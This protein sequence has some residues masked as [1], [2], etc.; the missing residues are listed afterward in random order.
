[1]RL[2]IITIMATLATIISGNTVAGSIMADTVC[3][4]G[5]GDTA[6]NDSNMTPVPEIQVLSSM[7]WKDDPES[8]KKVFDSV[9]GT[10]WRYF[11]NRQLHPILIQYSDKGPQTFYKRSS[12]GRYEIILDIGDRRHSQY[13]YQ[14]S[15]ELCHIL[16]GIDP[17]KEAADL[18]NQWFEEAFC[19][20]ASLFTLKRLAAVWRVFPPEPS[21]S[22]D[23]GRFLSYTANIFA[24][25]LPSVLPNYSE[26][27]QWLAK[28][29]VTL[30]EHA[31][32]DCPN[33]PDDC[34][35]DQAAR[36]KERVVA[37]FLLEMLEARPE[38]W[39]SLATLNTVL[40]E[41]PRTFSQ[42]LSDW[43]ACTPECHQPF[44]REI[45]TMFGIAISRPLSE[46]VTPDN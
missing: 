16:A 21:W 23:A 36:L 38:Q 45:A 31:Y 37:T 30:R 4:D 44:I 8:M 6:A 26:L 41:T 2:N 43:F 46:Q 34:P 9:I 27:P 28:N 25:H 11:P 32:T 17:R 15:H 42:Y 1:M 33:K 7:Q 22:D 10:I 12:N 18:S 39:E 19:E 14:F 5:V 24:K 13:V 3:K 40:S 29:E 20:A 35:R